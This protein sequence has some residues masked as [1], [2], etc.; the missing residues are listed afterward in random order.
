MIAVGPAHLFVMGNEADRDRIVAPVLRLGGMPVV[1]I[2]YSLARG[3]PTDY[4]MFSYRQFGDS[5]NACGIVGT[6]LAIADFEASRLNLEAA[7]LAK[8]EHSR[9]LLTGHQ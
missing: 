7:D 6:E 3:V 1:D 9:D 4:A 8:S 2:I 5:A